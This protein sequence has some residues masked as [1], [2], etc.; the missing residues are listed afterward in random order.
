MYEILSQ[1]ILNTRTH[2]ITW[3][4][5]SGILQCTIGDWTTEIST[6]HIWNENL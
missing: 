1:F 3:N 2:P 4:H 6:L 5:Q